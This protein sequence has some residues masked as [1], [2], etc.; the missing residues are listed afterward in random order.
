MEKDYSLLR[1]FDLEAAKR[2]E[3]LLNGSGSGDERSYVDGPDY[4]EVV[5]VKGKE[6]GLY[7]NSI[8]EMKMYP[9][10]WVEGRPVYKG[11][12]LYR[13]TVQKG[14]TLTV[15]GAFDMYGDNYL[16]FDGNNG[17]EYSDN[18]RSCLTWQKPKVKKSGWVN[19]YPNR[20]MCHLRSS[21][22]EADL[23]ATQCDGTID[24]ERVACIEIHWEE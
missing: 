8:H 16:R 14:I 13:T 20:S 4:F 17:T 21:K 12:V 5:C 9:L 10:A 23:T 15:I 24:P 18:R 1:P 7:L 19:V 22:E 2:G 11:D 3:K 6:G